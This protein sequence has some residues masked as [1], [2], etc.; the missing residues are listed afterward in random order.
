MS[1]DWNWAIELRESNFHKFEFQTDLIMCYALYIIPFVIRRSVIMIENPDPSP[2]VSPLI[3][4]NYF[5][6][7]NVISCYLDTESVLRR[8]NSLISKPASSD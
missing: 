6:Q 8:V 5:I 3:S 1:A 7:N 2:E 4:N